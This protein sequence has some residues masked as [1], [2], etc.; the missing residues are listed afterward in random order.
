LL[1]VNSPH[2]I[3]IEQDVQLPDSVASAL[4]IVTIPNFRDVGT[5]LSGL[6]LDQSNKL[7]DQDRI[8][9]VIEPSKLFR[10]THLS[11]IDEYQQQQLLDLGITDVIDLQSTKE[12]QEMGQSDQLP[13]GINYHH[14]EVDAM[15][16]EKATEDIM[17]ASD[18]DALPE[19]NAP[20]HVDLSKTFKFNNSTLD[21]SE[22]LYYSYRSMREL[23]A[24][25]VQSRQMRLAF[26]DALK[27]VSK[28]AKSGGGV[29]I[30]CRSG[31]DR[32]GWLVALLN[33][34]C[35]TSPDL[36]MLEYL[37]SAANA[38]T[39]ADILEDRY[40]SGDWQMFVPFA[41]VY[42]QYIRESIGQVF[43]LA[44]TDDWQIA[45]TEYLYLCGLTDGD[46][47]EIRTTFGRH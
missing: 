43:A 5:A 25:F 12:I 17:L 22:F 26:G 29:L 4:R 28:S 34:I 18:D 36:I 14:I 32:T 24:E 46:I 33:F 30:H 42:P 41:T 13:S 6:Q 39:A 10:S 7:H 31:K 37:L 40:Q 38:K 27:C 11:H 20:E 16:E 35:G 45:M 9:P 23:Y 44:G 19:I 1:N 15:L 47:D 3:E 2:L 8:S 21:K